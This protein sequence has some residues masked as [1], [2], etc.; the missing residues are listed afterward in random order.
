MCEKISRELFIA[1]GVPAPRAAHALVKLNGRDLGLYVV[2]E[3][4]NRQFL[5]RFF[6]N[7]SGN[8]YDGGFCRDV[9]TSLAVNC[10]DDP[11]NN[12]GLRALTRAVHSRTDDLG[13]LD[14]VLDVDRFISM[15]AM[16]MILCHWDGYTMNRNNWR[17]FHDL[18]SNRMVF[19]P[20][21]LDQ[22]FGMGVQFEPGKTLKPDHVMG[23]V[24]QAVLASRE[25][26]AR[27]KRRVGELYTNVFKADAVAARVELIA[28]AVSSDVA[29]SHPQLARSVEIQASGLEER[30]LRRGDQVRR[31]LGVPLH[32]LH[33]GP[34]GAITLAGWKRSTSRSGQPLLAQVKDPEGKTLLS[35]NAGNGVSSSSWRARVSLLPGRYQFEGR[36]R[37]NDVTIDP[38]DTR[39]GAGLRISK[40]TMPHKLTGTTPWTDFKYLFEV[41][42]DGDVELIC[43]LRAAKGEALFD[44]SSLRLMQVR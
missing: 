21:G 32:P 27:Y 4:A 3:G 10:G 35:I 8:L 42:D 11:T 38:G 28:H 19:I 5:K 7:T 2:L 25:G 18:D 12:S 24:S 23:D 22:L 6:K 29:T 14:K 15:M 36:V 9:S 33:F 16:E 20:H 30:I 43:E 37:V 13:R 17:I 39:G 41:S 40:G 26:L 31:D 34:D 1:A 44:T